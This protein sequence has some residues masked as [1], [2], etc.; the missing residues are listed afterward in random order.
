MAALEERFSVYAP[1]RDIYRLLQVDPRAD[2][3]TIVAACRRL[4]RYYHPDYNLSPRATEEM[5][6]VNAV[7]RVMTDP[8]ARARYDH[9]RQR[10]LAAQAAI[11]WPAAPARPHPPVTFPRDTRLPQGSAWPRFHADPTSWPQLAVL[12]LPARRLGIRTRALFIGLGAGIAALAPERCAICR[13]AIGTSDRYCEACGTPLLA[14]N[15][16]ES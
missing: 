12:G 14:M 5:Q 6:V 2:T 4:A 9:A 16:A 10:W 7:R 3:D 8:A 11:R 1:E 13:A 15:A